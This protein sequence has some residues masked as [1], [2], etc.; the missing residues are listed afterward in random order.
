MASEPGRSERRW[1]SVAA[2]RYPYIAV[3]AMVGG[4]TAFGFA[5]GPII[6]TANLDVLYL[7]A[8]FVSALRWGRRPAVFC[9]LTAGV[10]FDFCFIPPKFSFH[11][12]DLP[13]L[14]T[15]VAFV[16]VAI[17]TSELATRARDVIL[18]ERVRADAEAARADAAAARA[19]LEAVTQAK[20]VLLDRIAHELRSPLTAILGRV[21]LLQKTIGDPDETGRSVAKLGHSA[22]IL[23]RLVGDLL[24]LSRM[25]AAKLRV[26]L[27]PTALLPSVTRAVD[28]L[29]IAAAEKGV[30]LESTLEPVADILADPDRIEQIV[31]N[32]VSNAIK[33]TPQGGRIT[34]QLRQTALAIALD[35]AD[36]GVGIPADF[37]PHVFEP[38]SQSDTGVKHDGLGLG[39]AIVKNLVDAHGAEIS[40]SSPGPGKGTTFS[41]VFP[42]GRLDESHVPPMSSNDVTSSTVH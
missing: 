35:V 7:L 1:M 17:I 20:D 26:R 5:A 8:V 32:L 12:S 9:A 10:V 30:G 15:L 4:V 34:V 19:E 14:I 37:V 22:Q 29:A 21:Q 24:D 40:V 41:V 2:D 27:Q 25:H 28:D 16:T 38:F 3:S 6:R 33:F 23:A 39:L 18:A 11:I 36:T 42:L 31:N 13:Y